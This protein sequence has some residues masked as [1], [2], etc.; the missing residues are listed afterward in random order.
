M[1][2]SLDRTAAFIPIDVPLPGDE[3][4]A[5]RFHWLDPGEFRMGTRGNKPEEEP[6]HRVTVPGFWMAKYV[7]TQK[8]WN[9]ITTHLR[10]KILPRAPSH[11]M[12]RQLS[13]RL[14]EW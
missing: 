6:Q 8:Q 5:I 11:F 3:R 14:L 4:S 1:A 7:V 2:E 10:E 12:P 13:H 9:A